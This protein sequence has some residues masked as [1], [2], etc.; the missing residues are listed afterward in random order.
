MKRHIKE[1]GRRAL[2][3]GVMMTF[4]L[5]AAPLLSVT[6]PIA[7]LGICGTISVRIIAKGD[8]GLEVR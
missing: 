4:G 8:K 5:V 6:V 7:V 1:A 3:A 2:G